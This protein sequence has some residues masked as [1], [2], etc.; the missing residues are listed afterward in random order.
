MSIQVELPQLPITTAFENSI[1][2]TI[3]SDDQE[4]DSIRIITTNF[5]NTKK[6][7]NKRT[8]VSEL[9]FIHH[10]LIF[11]RIFQVK[12]RRNVL[13]ESELLSNGKLSKD[14]VDFYLPSSSISNID[15]EENSQ[16]DHPSVCIETAKNI[17]HLLETLPSD[18]S[19][20]TTLLLKCI[21]IKNKISEYITQTNEPEFLDQ[22]FYHFDKLNQI[23]N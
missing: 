2:S 14:F 18:D 12:R 15:D 7:R 23:I 3:Q 11:N 9:D 6:L 8:K 5:G 20:I 1:F 10:F 19:E 4:Q 21:D 17:V 22:L 16:N 13:V